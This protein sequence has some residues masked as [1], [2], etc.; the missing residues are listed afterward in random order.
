VRKDGNTP[1]ISVP[2]QFKEGC[3]AN[4]PS[5]GMASGVIQQ[6]NKGK[7]TPRNKTN[8]ERWQ[9]LCWLRAIFF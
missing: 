9:K 8:A 1:G 2:I 6:T 5:R 4:V 3:S 7:A